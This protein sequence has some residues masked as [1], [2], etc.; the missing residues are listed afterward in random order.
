MTWEVGAG[1]GTVLSKAVIQDVAVGV[2]AGKQNSTHKCVT[3]EN[4][5]KQLPELQARLREATKGC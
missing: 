1:E 4:F 3:E 5:V 2:P